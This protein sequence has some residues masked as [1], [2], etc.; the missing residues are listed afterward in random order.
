MSSSYK[1]LQVHQLSQ[2]FAA[3]VRVVRQPLLPPSTKQLLIKV[4]YAGVNATDVNMSAGRYFTPPKPPFGVGLEALGVVAGVGSSVTGFQEGDCVLVVMGTACYAEYT[5]ASQSQVFKVDSLDPRFLLSSISGLTAAIGLEKCG[6][7][8][9]GETLLVTAAAGGT[10]H[11]AV[12]WG[13]RLGAHVVGVTSS[14][15]KAAVLQQLGVDHVINYRKEDLMQALSRD[16]PQGVDVIWETLG[17]GWLDDLFEHLKP[18]GRLVIVGGTSA[19][20]REDFP[21]TRI[22]GLTYKLRVRGTSLTGFRLPLYA[23]LMP[24]YQASLA[25]D[26]AN[27]SLTAIMDD[28]TESSGKAFQGIHE[29]ARAVAHLHSGSSVGK[30]VVKVA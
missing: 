17:A 12:Q 16:F 18:R 24:E 22:K 19:Y 14:D 30:V 21:E 4:V 13:K 11:V 8:T 10:G 3:A 1:A 28:G 20:K 23:D 9:K 6:R 25:R 29:V 15:S 26:I 2:D 27:G 7:L 5:L